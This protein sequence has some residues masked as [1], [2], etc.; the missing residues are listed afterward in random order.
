[1]IGII[2]TTLLF[3]FPGVLILLDRRIFP[4]FYMAEKIPISI[5]FSLSYWVIGF[6]FLS[7]IPISISVFI[8]LSLLLSVTVFILGVHRSRAYSFTKHAVLTNLTL[9]ITLSTLG[10]PAFIL[11]AHQIAPSGADMS[12]HA[13]LAKAI[14]LTNGFPNTLEPLVPVTHFGTYPVGFPAIVADMMI[15]NALPVYTNAMWLTAC[16][17]WFFAVCLYLLLRTRYLPITSFIA[18]CIVSWVSLTPHDFIEWG[19]NPT[20]LSLDFVLLATIWVTLTKHRWMPFFFCTTLLTSLLIH[21]IVPVAAGYLFLLFLPFLWTPIRAYVKNKN[22][23]LNILIACILI[24]FPVA[25][26]LLGNDLTISDTATSYVS[27]L[28]QQELAEWAGTT[29]PSW[30]IGTTRFLVQVFGSRIAL[31]YALSLVCILFTRPRLAFVHL[32]FLIGI[33]A[34]IINA[35]YWILPFSPMLYPKRVALLMLIPISH[36]VAYLAHTVITHMKG[37]RA[38]R[39]G[40]VIL[41]VAYAYHPIMNLNIRRFIQSDAFS[42]V[43]KNDL[44]ALNWL[45]HNTNSEDI[46][47]NNYWDAGIWIPA[48]SDRQIILYHTNPIDM[49]ALIARTATETYAYIGSKTLRAEGDDS[50]HREMLSKDP[51]RFTRVYQ[52]GG[53]EIYRVKRSAHIPTP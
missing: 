29:S 38:T 8:Y 36:A 41:L 10:I 27:Q 16:T 51:T 14:Y 23:M 35:Q 33:Y 24:T 28:H 6:W 7:V 3:L 48:I 44:I 46:I 52:K 25:L 15:I 1:M 50:I 20:I 18:T 17:Y 40:V 11:A 42:A 45:K 39:Y 34:L 5:G 30:L 13:Y 22:H 21:Y 37:N 32:L 4:S 19:G 43:T 26:H 2:L 31:L 47:L 53:V 9:L 49:D 12:M